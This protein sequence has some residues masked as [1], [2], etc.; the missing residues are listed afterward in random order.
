[1]AALP[2]KKRVM[3]S[4]KIGEISAVDV[5]ANEHATAPLMKS[6]HG[7]EG[8]S[9]AKPREAYSKQ[10]NEAATMRAECEAMYEK[11]VATIEVNEKCSRSDAYGKA[12]SDAF[13]IQCYELAERC[14]DREAAARELLMRLGDV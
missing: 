5:P 6:A 3:R 14:R 11:R 8:L 10:A 9:I 13:A 4:L 12:A 1:M 7:A 2:K